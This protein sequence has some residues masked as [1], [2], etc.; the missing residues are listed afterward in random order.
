MMNKAYFDYHGF[1][2][3][4]TNAIRVNLKTPRLNYVMR[5]ACELLR[6]FDEPIQISTIDAWEK[7]FD[8]SKG[9]MVGYLKGIKRV[10]Q[11]NFEA[12]RQRM[13]QFNVEQNIINKEVIISDNFG[14]VHTIAEVE[15]ILKAEGQKFT[16]AELYKLLEPLNKNITIVQPFDP[17]KRYFE[18]LAQNYKGGKNIKELADCIPIREFQ[19]KGRQN[20][21]YRKKM[22]YYLAKWLYKTAGQALGIGINDAMLLWVEGKGGSGKSRMNDW[23]CNTLKPFKDYYTPIKEN[24]VYKPFTEMA[25]TRFFVDFDELPI[26]G[27]RYQDFK[28]SIASTEVKVYKKGIGWVTYKKMASFIGSTNKNNEG[29]QK[30]YVV[31]P[32]EA[33]MRRV[34]PIEIPAGEPIDFERYLRNVDLEQLWGEA[35]AGIIQAEKSNNTD[36]LRYT[37][38]DYDYLIE[39]NKRYLLDNPKHENSIILRYVKKAPE[40]VARYF[41]SSSQILE[42]ITSKGYKVAKN[43][44]ALGM[45]LKQANF[46]KYRNGRQRGWFVEFKV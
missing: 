17:L 27:T 15:E 45:L 9:M 43:E 14:V 8:L 20:G 7:Q 23:M 33:F 24:S 5:R 22:E 28:S 34:I 10:N 3:R 44:T 13:K 36:L 21:F 41:Y 30:G 25:A 6:R 11:T 2:G 29:T 26:S 32:D 16:K 4:Y 35:A 1:Y 12:L 42:H 18:E 39:Q 38:Q 31:E 46:T 37:K 40:N 19:D